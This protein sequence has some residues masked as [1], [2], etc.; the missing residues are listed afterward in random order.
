MPVTAVGKIFKPALRLDAMQRA[1]VKTVRATLGDRS[2]VRV[3]VRETGAR[4]VV[5]LAVP[6]GPGAETAEQL[7]RTAFSG[8]TFETRIV[9]DT[10]T[11]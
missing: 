7:L 9:I 8:Y 10:L 4:P 11:E 6:H 3:E 2:E 5:T 1:A